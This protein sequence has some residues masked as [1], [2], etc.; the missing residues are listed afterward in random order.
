M[1]DTTGIA[2]QVERSTTVEASAAALISGFKGLLDTAIAEAVKANDDA[3]LT[4]LTDLSAKMEA[5]TSA[6][7]AAVVANTPAAP[8]A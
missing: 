7:E 3:D 6:L 5:S 8:P 4:A 2:S 1:A